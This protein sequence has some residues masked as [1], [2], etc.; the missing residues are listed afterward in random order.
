M[1][2]IG[3]HIINSLFSLI[4]FIQM[5]KEKPIKIATFAL[6]IGLLNDLRKQLKQHMKLLRCLIGFGQPRRDSE[7]VFALI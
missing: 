4:L 2:N 7:G 3:L 6:I 5:R 1:V